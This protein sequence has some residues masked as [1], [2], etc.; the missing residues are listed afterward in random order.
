MNDQSKNPLNGEQQRI[1]DHI[2]GPILV[3]AP[4]GTGKTRVLAERVVNA[5]QHGIPAEKVLCLTFTNRAAQEMRDRLSKY[6]YEAARQ[7]TIKTFHALCTHMLQVEARHIGL[8]T[9][10]VIYDDVDSLELVKD[11]FK[12]QKETDAKDMVW[13]ISECKVCAPK[14]QLSISGPSEIIFQSLGGNLA[15]RAAQ[16]QAI[17]RQRH[18]LDFSD[19]IYFTR[20]M[21]FE[22]PDIQDRWGKRYNFIQVDEVQDTCTRSSPPQSQPGYDW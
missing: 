22:R 11:I 13:R 10:F 14:H 18:A 17:L 7:A 19:L 12:I 3:V 9:D 8:P 1:V 4:V 5:V 16:Y 20:A 21:L 2:Q 15:L 6:S